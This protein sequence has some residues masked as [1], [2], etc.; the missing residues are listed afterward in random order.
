MRLLSASHL[1]FMSR[2]GSPFTSWRAWCSLVVIL[3]ERAIIGAFQMHQLDSQTFLFPQPSPDILNGD[4]VIFFYIIL[5][6]VASQVLLLRTNWC[7]RLSDLIYLLFVDLQSHLPKARPYVLDSNITLFLWVCRVWIRGASASALPLN[8]SDTVNKVVVSPH[9]KYIIY[10]TYITSIHDSRIDIMNQSKIK[11]SSSVIFEKGE[12]TLWFAVP[13][14]EQTIVEE[15]WKGGVIIL[16][17]R[18]FLFHWPHNQAKHFT[19]V[20]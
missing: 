20:H 1:V 6:L 10:C 17:G 7:F 18:G 14:P 4:T 2:I 8:S 16:V 19:Q 15:Q 13:P 11:T 5:I 9:K 3:L 12:E